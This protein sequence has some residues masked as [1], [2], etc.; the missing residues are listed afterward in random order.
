MLFIWFTGIVFLWYTAEMLHSDIYFFSKRT[1]AYCTA[2]CAG[3]F[4]RIR[5]AFDFGARK[6]GK[7]LQVPSCLTVGE[8]NQFFRNTLKRN[9][10]GLRPDVLVVSS[11]LVTNDPVSSDLDVERVN[12]VAPNNSCDVLS[13]QLSNINISDSN[14]H[15]SIKQKEC[16]SMADHKEIKSVS[17]G[18][19]D[20]DATN[21]ATTDSVSI[22]GGGNFSEASP[23]PSETST[24]QSETGKKV[25]VRNDTTPSY[26]GVSA[27]QFTGRSHHYIEDTKHNAYPYST[28]LVDG[29]GTS[30]SVLTS[31]TQPGGNNNDTVPNLT[32]DFDTN[33]HNLLYARG[34]HQDNPMTQLYYPMPMP[35][36]LQYQNMHPSNGHGRKN[37][38]GY[39]GRNGVVP[40]HVY[41]PSYFVYRPLY[42]ADD[43]MTLRT[44]G[45]GT[46]FPD[47]VRSLLDYIHLMSLKLKEHRHLSICLFI[48][49][50]C[51]TCE[52]KY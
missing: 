5:S 1:L 15:G 3:N 34:F 12:N 14:N 9:R 26:Y 33:L 20:S 24:L 37:P 28:G 4:Y 8:V 17:L 16:N 7:I 11:D 46:Y 41:P 2:P 27:K 19:L 43:H 31:D 6:L 22:R 49:S 25:D 18:L 30:N 35:P 21:H 48:H 44:R 32:G 52:Q 39:A 38:Y 51:C 47:P 10:T 23:V 45:T 13:N 40:G 36:P 42:Q 29:L 50:V